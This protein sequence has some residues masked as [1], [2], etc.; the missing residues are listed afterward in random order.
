MLKPETVTEAKRFTDQPPSGGCVL[1]PLRPD[2]RH[3]AHNQPPSGG[4]VLK[5]ACALLMNGLLKPAA[6]R[7]LCVETLPHSHADPI[8]S[9]AAFRRLCVET[10]ANPAIRRME[11]QPP[12][13]GCVL[14][15]SIPFQRRPRIIQP[16][17]GGCVLKLPL[18]RHGIP[19]AMPA[20][21][22][23]LCVETSVRPSVM[24]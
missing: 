2:R 7:R 14:K 12:S 17:S 21:F 22:R 10:V 23:R 9:P 15:Q 20:A 6:F 13:G 24:D 1:K 19:I 4:C 11:L 5:L 18:S 8:F 16:P 3:H